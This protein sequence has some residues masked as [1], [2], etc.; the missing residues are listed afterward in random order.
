MEPAQLAGLMHC[1]KELWISLGACFHTK[2]NKSGMKSYFKSDFTSGLR[3]DLS[4]AHQNESDKCTY[5][6]LRSKGYKVQ[7]HTFVIRLLLVKISTK[8]VSLCSL[9]GTDCRKIG[10]IL[11]LLWSILS[12]VKKQGSCKL[13]L[14]LQC[15]CVARWPEGGHLRKPCLGTELRECDRR[16]VLQLQR[17]DVCHCWKVR[18]SLDDRRRRKNLWTYL[19]LERVLP[20]IQGN[21]SNSVLFACVVFLFALNGPTNI[22]QLVPLRHFCLFYI[23]QYVLKAAQ[24][25]HMHRFCFW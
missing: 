21:L 2:A 6:C 20:D 11:L 13:L 22:H 5:L 1:P 4:L 17:R 9:V 25:T 16:G 19:L 10:F 24:G 7:F 14:V 12:N 8:G 3:Y 18:V 15:S 23:E